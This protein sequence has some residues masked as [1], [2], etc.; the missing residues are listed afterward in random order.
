MGSSPYLHLTRRQR[1]VSMVV[2]LAPPCMTKGSFL[3]QSRAE[4]RKELHACMSCN[5]Y[6]YNSN[7]K[8]NNNNIRAQSLPTEPSRQ[9]TDR[10]RKL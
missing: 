2:T 5:Y 7:N 3:K 9:W 1:Q 10:W 8:N 6:S 4:G